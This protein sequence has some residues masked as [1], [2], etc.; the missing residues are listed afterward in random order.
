MKIIYSTTKDVFLE[1]PI[2]EIINNSL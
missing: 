2:N 1:I